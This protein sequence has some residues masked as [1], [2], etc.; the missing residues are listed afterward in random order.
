VEIPGLLPGR[1][2]RPLL[3]GAS[4]E[5]AGWRSATL[6]E[7]YTPAVEEMGQ[8]R[9]EWGRGRGQWTLREKRWKLIHR[10]GARSA[11]YD[12]QSDPLELRNL[13]DDPEHVQEKARLYALLAQGTIQR[14]EQFPALWEPVVTVAGPAVSVAQ[15]S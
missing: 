7:Q 4:S 14:A 1:S 2:L 9:T 3:H 10:A 15:R 5:E 6:S 12:L 13:I 11:L 8:G